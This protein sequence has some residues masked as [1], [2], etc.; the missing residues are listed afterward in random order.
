MA[1]QVQ[2]Q[3]P[4]TQATPWFG[5]RSIHRL[6]E[7]VGLHVV[8]LAL[9]A[10]FVLPLVWMISTSFKSLEQ[11]AVWPPIWLP[12]PLAWQNYP[13]AFNFL[14]LARYTLNTLIITLLFVVGTFFSCPIVAY[15]F[16]RIEFPGRD[17]LFIVLIATIMLPGVVRLIPTYLMFERLGWLNTY[18]PLVI[19]AFVGTPFYIFLLRQYF[20]TF[21]EEL[22]DAARIDGATE[23]DILTRIFLPMSGPALAV[24]T[25]FA[26][27]SQWND[28]VDPLIYLNKEELR[29]LALGL[30]YFRAY[31]DTTNWGQM[32]A[33]AMMMT[34]PILI[35]FALF[36]RY[37]IQGV[38][39][40]G[41]KG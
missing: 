12:S 24:I 27:Q 21:P 19:P 38:A 3:L 13:D 9:A 39:L 16:A 11:Q 18:L 41:M 15:A 22:A 29:T 4:R 23:F 31:Q 1:E 36:Q 25:I 40:T 2:T 30:C 28:F 37:F 34:T 14:P 8:L 7:M 17:F 5:R 6:I 20:R 35:L 26:I 32:M 33:A 10:L